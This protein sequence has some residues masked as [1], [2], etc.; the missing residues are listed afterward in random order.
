MKIAIHHSQGSFSEQW[1]EYCKTHSIDY[2]VVNSYDNDIVSQVA[3]CDVFMWHHHHGDYRD[4][5]F[6]KQLL[7]SLQISGKAV[8]PDATTNWHFDDKVG[9]KYLFEAINAPLVPTFVFYNKEDAIKWVQAATF[10]KVFKLKGGAGA[11]NV[12]L[13]RTKN[14]AIKFINR[15]F[16]KG[17][18]QFDRWGNFKERFNRWRNGDDSFIGVL[19][20]IA[21][22]F[23]STDFSKLH[24]PEK[25]YVYF[26]EFIPNNEYDIRIVVINDKAFAIK[27]LCRKDDFRASGSGHIIYRKEEIDERC[28]LISFRVSNQMK[29]QSAAFDYVFDQQNK[30]LIVEVSYG[31]SMH[32][33]DL[34]PG[35]WSSDMIWHE[36]TFNPQQWMIEDVIKAVHMRS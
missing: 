6:A 25:G 7:C 22:L 36:G 20:G 26:Q 12:K 35:Y 3:D 8:F 5:L 16:S 30:P 24:S 15:A 31:F 14:E 34:C 18:A 2:K 27:R 1:I 13:A 10:P 28:V 23:V 17:F 21:R 29:S 4:V 32:G 11:A 33:Y 9:Q 19:K